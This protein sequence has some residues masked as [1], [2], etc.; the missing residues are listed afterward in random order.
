MTF[1][2]I[3][4]DGLLGVL[5]IAALMLGVRLDRRLKTLRESH[6]G[7]AQAVGDLDRAAARAEQGLADL[8]AATDEAADVLAARIEKAQLLS[9]KLETQAERA[10]AA[11]PPTLVRERPAA[12]SRDLFNRTSAPTPVREVAAQRP[13]LLTPRSRA[14]VDDDLFA[15]EAPATRA[16]G[17]R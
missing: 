10:A 15:E 3:I 14:R 1:V 4:L 16:A 11:P 17:G 8:R 2:P 9:M 6:L 5:L 12:A 13:S 7:F